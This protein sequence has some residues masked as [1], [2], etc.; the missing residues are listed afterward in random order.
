MGF[1]HTILLI[2][3]GVATTAAV[4]FFRYGFDLLA[5]WFPEEDSGDP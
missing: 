1:R 5:S 3:V 2:A 4:L